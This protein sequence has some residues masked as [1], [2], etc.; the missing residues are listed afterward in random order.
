[1]AVIK[2]TSNIPTSSS[3]GGSNSNAKQLYQHII[4]G[5]GTPGDRNFYVYFTIIND[6]DT[7]LDFTAIKQ[8]LSQ[9]NLI[10]NTSNW[11]TSSNRPYPAT[12]R[13]YNGSNWTDIDFIA[14]NVSNS[15][16]C[17]G[18]RQAGSVTSVNIQ[19]NYFEDT[20]IAL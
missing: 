5:F 20:V 13:F 9:H 15:L 3:G 17:V 6:S 11:G 14:I 7:T 4:Y 18:S 10:I 12:G 19:S 1:M 2:G 16:L 8:Y